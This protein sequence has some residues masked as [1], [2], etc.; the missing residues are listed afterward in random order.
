MGADGETFDVSFVIEQIGDGPG[1][2][3]RSIE[4]NPDGSNFVTEYEAVPS[5]TDPYVR[6]RQRTVGDG[7]PR[8]IVTEFLP[9]PVRP[10]TYPDGFPF[11][12]GRR[13][14]TTESPAHSVSPGVTWP[15][16]DPEVALAALI[17]ASLA[18]GWVRV[19]PVDVPSFM[20]R[21]L[22]A[23]FRRGRD[24]HLFHRA[25]HAQGSVIQMMALDAAW[26]DSSDSRESPGEG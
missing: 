1:R 2:L 7:P 23:A 5:A 11:L 22:G 24:V 8:E 6:S 9:S 25:D 19:A 18:D 12:A 21:N 20:R 3:V 17:E 26:L 15:C 14:H 10:P 13:S 4:T 16:D